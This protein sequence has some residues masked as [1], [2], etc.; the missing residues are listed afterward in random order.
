MLILLVL[1]MCLVLLPTAFPPVRASLRDT[2]TYCTAM[3]CTALS[4]SVPTDSV[5]NWGE[6]RVTFTEA[7]AVF[8]LHAVGHRSNQNKPV[9]S[10]MDAR[11]RAQILSN[12]DFVN[13]VNS[14]WTSQGNLVFVLFFHSFLFSF[15][16]PHERSHMHLLNDC[17]WHLS[18]HFLFVVPDLSLS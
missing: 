12:L 18:S 7:A 1:T 6:K 5:I 4:V 10:F 9:T 15:L 13:H 3:H 11:R 16:N 8:V 17:L 14:G 2:A